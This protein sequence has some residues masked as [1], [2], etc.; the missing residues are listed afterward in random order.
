MVAIPFYT[1]G[2]WKLNERMAEMNEAAQ[3][4]II[5][6]SHMPS[7]VFT[8]AVTEHTFFCDMLV[9]IQASNNINSEEQD[10]IM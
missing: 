6:A 8:C 9:A 10:S 2:L 5:L 3:P 4:V 7:C 1:I